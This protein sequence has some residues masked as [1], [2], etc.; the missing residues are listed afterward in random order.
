MK[1]MTYL[2]T[3]PIFAVSL[4]LPALAEFTAEEQATIDFC[5]TNI[6]SKAYSP[7]DAYK[8]L[9]AIHPDATLFKKLKDEDKDTLNY[10]LKYDGVI[11]ELGDFFRD[12]PGECLIKERYLAMLEASGDQEGCVLC[13]MDMAPQPDKTFKWISTY[14]NGSSQDSMKAGLAWSVAGAPRQPMFTNMGV[15]PARWM[16]MTVSERTAAVMAETALSNKSNYPDVITKCWIVNGTPQ[17]YMDRNLP[18]DIRASIRAYLAKVMPA[19]AA[20]GSGAASGTD[21]SK[22]ASAADRAK[23]MAGKSDAEMMAYLGGMFDKKSAAAK[24]QSPENFAKA[25]TAKPGAKEDP[26][27]YTLPVDKLDKVAA[28]V[29]T[30][31]LGGV[32]ELDGKPR[33]PAFSGT[34]W[35]DEALKFYTAKGKDG[36]PLHDLNFGIQVM[37]KNTNGGYCPQHAGTNGCGTDFPAGSIR[38]NKMLVEEWMKKNKITADQLTSDPKLMD[39]LGRHL[40]VVM[41]HEGPVH[42]VRQDQFYIANGVD[43]KKILDKE[44]MAFGLSTL[45]LKNK[46]NGPEGALYRREASDFDLKTL[47]A[48]EDGGYRGIKSFV[49]YYDL[50]GVQG[51]GAKSIKQMEAGLKEMEL[52]KTDP[53]YASQAKVTNLCSW[54]NIQNCSDAQLTSMTQKAYPWYETVIARQKSETAMLNS[55]LEEEINQSSLR[56]SLKA[57]KIKELREYDGEGL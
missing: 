40:Y 56:K 15:T 32:S 19:P 29:K 42:E 44:A 24:F 11:K 50:E 1:K 23:A 38:V 52:R 14:Y 45:S 36:K 6:E 39:R 57:K 46:F 34:Q 13:D 21:P 26:A 54:Y 43:N 41:V 25:K 51:V 2:L 10:I 47:K 53:A 12:K 5:K 22:Y 35:E 9:Q 33:K 30:R 48:V 49:R 8:C 55:A 31:M 37:S 27:K 20:A 4:A 7:K 16:Q 17:Q 28:E 3:L 18:A